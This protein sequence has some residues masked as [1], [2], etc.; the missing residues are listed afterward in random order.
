[1]LGLSTRT[2]ALGAAAVALGVDVVY[3]VAVAAEDGGDPGARVALVAATL[4]GAGVLA[5]VA[6][7]V[8]ADALALVLLTACGAVLVFWGIL[9]LATIG[10]PLLVGGLFAATAAVQAAEHATPDAFRAAMAAAVGI[11]GALA[12]AYAL[13]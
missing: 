4:A 1:M 7:L 8:A 6:A 10:I 3:L 5:L 11:V 2:L 13:S 9:G 12:I